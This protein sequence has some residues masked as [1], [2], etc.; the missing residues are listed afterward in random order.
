MPALAVTRKGLAPD[1]SRHGNGIQD[2]LH[3]HRRF[4]GAFVT[5]Q[6][7]HEPVWAAMRNENLR[8]CSTLN[9]GRSPLEH[10][11]AERVT[12]SVAKQPE[13]VEIDGHERERGMPA[14]Y[15]GDETRE[16]FGPLRQRGQPRQRMAFR[17]CRR[18]AQIS[19]RF[20]A[21]TGLAWRRSC[22]RAPRQPGTRPF[23]NFN[24]RCL[25][26]CHLRSLPFRC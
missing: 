9:D 3:A 1:I 15:I 2:L 23:E 5:D 22:G 7:K 4:N 14:P 18:Y 6:R 21:A 16:V 20:S 11:V 10:V 24:H 13:A 12:V 17:E 8:A 19:R 26:V 25:P